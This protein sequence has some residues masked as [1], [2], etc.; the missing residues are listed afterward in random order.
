MDLKILTPSL[1]FSQGLVINRA[2]VGVIHLITLVI[3]GSVLGSVETKPVEILLSALLTFR[4]LNVMVLV[5][6]RTVMD[7]ELLT[8]GWN[9]PNIK[10]KK[11]DIFFVYTYKA[12][13]LGSL[14]RKAPYP[15]ELAAVNTRS[16]YCILLARN[17]RIGSNNEIPP[18][19][20]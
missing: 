10:K 4:A 5:S 8:L 2:T 7:G 14:E 15:V 18:G 16:S 12:P 13:P 11:G 3:L 1:R 19:C 9:Q 6:V 17:S 20:I